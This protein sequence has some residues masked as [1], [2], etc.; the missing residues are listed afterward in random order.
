MTAL[1]LHV[2]T[3]VETLLK[4]KGTGKTGPRSSVRGVS[5]L[6][7]A[8]AALVCDGSPGRDTRKRVLSFGL[9]PGGAGQRDSL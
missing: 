1:Q 9:R 7:I 5:P 8:N 4:T 3:H 6:P 2:K